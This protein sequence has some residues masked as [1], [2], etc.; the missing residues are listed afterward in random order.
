MLEWIGA[1]CFMGLI[2]ILWPVVKCLVAESHSTLLLPRRESKRS[3]ERC[4]SK[5]E[6][7]GEPDA[8]ALICKPS[9][10]ANYLLKHCMSFCKSLSIPKWTWRMSSSLQTVFGALWPF[11]CPVHF[12][13]DHLQLSDD[14][15]VALDWAVVGAAHHKRRRTCSNS[16]SP[17]LLIIPNSFGKI[18]RNVLKV[19]VLFK[20]SSLFRSKECGR[21]TVYCKNHIVYILK[22]RLCN[23]FCEYLNTQKS[24]VS[25][26][27]I[28]L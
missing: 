10:L 15:V 22:N 6:G 19:M 8:L 20:H 16:T 27:S 24:N 25:S 26:K 21:C 23:F 9:A 11:D 3:A 28:Y 12:I 7:Q 1:A 18:T 17:V 2:A 4:D 5:L 13:R 14:G